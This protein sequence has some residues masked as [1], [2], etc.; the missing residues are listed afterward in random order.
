ML[1]GS[2]DYENPQFQVNYSLDREVHNLH[3]AF[4][5]LG[6]K[7]EKDCMWKSHARS[8]LESS[9]PF[10]LAQEPSASF[11]PL[12]SKRLRLARFGSVL[13]SSSSAKRTDV[14]ECLPL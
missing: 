12:W 10:I 8:N 7:S 14:L 11:P 2:F 5:L 9:R 6:R 1:R 3:H 4:I 13:R